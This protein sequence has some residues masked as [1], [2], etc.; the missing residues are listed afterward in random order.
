[1]GFVSFGFLVD[2]LQTE[3]ELRDRPVAQVILDAAALDVIGQLAI[4]GREAGIESSAVVVVEIGLE[5]T[6]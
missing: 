1:M 3:F 6:D 5:Q 4:V 2:T